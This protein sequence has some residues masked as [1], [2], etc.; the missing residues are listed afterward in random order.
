MLL[1]SV[2]LFCFQFFFE[3]EFF[4]LGFIIFF[5]NFFCQSSM[6]CNSCFFISLY[7]Y[8][9]DCIWVRHL[10]L[11]SIV[12]VCDS[13]INVGWNICSCITNVFESLS[14][15]FTRLM[16]FNFNSQT[17]STK[18]SFVIKS[19]ILWHFAC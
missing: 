1:F 16:S 17:L 4:Q 11:F 10:I 9:L 14:V 12:N 18:S 8:T 2:L 7:N 5:K 13:Y 19:S 3:M 6:L 15:L